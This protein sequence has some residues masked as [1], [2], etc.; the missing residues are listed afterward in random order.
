MQAP[1]K[2]K[3]TTAIYCVKSFVKWHACLLAFFEAMISLGISSH[4]KARSGAG[5][6]YGGHEYL[7]PTHSYQFRNLSNCSTGVCFDSV[8]SPIT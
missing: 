4:T 5:D 6:Y 7:L 1:T 3:K 2:I 8:T